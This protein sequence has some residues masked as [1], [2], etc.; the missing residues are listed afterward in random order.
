MA[1]RGMI[2]FT[3]VVT[4]ALP[5]LLLVERCTGGKIVT[6]LLLVLICSLLIIQSADLNI[7]N[8]LHH[9][10]KQLMMK[11]APRTCRTSVQVRGSKYHWSVL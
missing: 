9:V 6:I 5:I 8:N 10:L 3:L 4:C 1:T 7:E 2:G 11:I